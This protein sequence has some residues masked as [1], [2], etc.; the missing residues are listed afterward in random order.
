MTWNTMKQQRKE[1]VRMHMVRSGYPL[2]RLAHKV[3]FLIEEY[4]LPRAEASRKAWP[5]FPQRASN[6][7]QQHLKFRKFAAAGFRHQEIS[8]SNGGGLC[9]L[10]KAEQ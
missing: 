10:P 7:Y 5:L 4:G 2:V 9:M 3:A 1:A 6:A 8:D